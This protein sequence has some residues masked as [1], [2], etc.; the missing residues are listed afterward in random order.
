MDSYEHKSNSKAA[1]KKKKRETEIKEQETNATH[2]V[3][4]LSSLNGK[5]VICNNMNI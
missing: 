3:L 1:R 5:I 2:S 4:C